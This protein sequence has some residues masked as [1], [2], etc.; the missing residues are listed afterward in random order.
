[1]QL[2]PVAVNPQIQSCLESQSL[3]MLLDAAERLGR[4]PIIHDNRL[5][6]KTIIN[7]IAEWK[8]ENRIC[9][10]LLKQMFF[11]NKKNVIVD[12]NFDIYDIKTEI[13]RRFDNCIEKIDEHTRENITSMY[14]SIQE[15]FDSL[16]EFK[17]DN[18]GK[19][20][21]LKAKFKR[22]EIPPVSPTH[23]TIEDFH[24]R[25]ILQ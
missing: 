1:M 2:D 5:L 18:Y 12:V 20:M 22:Y 6:C 8:H 19:Y 15:Y 16:F 14:K 23:K 3:T 4:K 10:R 13:Y 25:Q 11:G 9:Y 7:K 17:P 21:L 24:N